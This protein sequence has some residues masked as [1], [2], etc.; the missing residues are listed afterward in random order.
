M[1]KNTYLEKHLRTA[2]SENQHEILYRKFLF[3]TISI[4]N[5]TMTE[6]FYQ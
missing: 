2:A 3:L 5:F 4:L 6:W 1:F